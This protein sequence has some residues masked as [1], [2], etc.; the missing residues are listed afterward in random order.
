MNNAGGTDQI[1]GGVIEVEG[2]EGLFSLRV[3]DNQA[4]T[5]HP[6]I[7]ALT[8]S[9]VPGVVLAFFMPCEPAGATNTTHSP[10]GGFTEFWD[11]TVSGGALGPRGISTGKVDLTGASSFAP[12]TTNDN[13]AVSTKWAGI[14]LML[15]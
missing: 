15:S 1:T 6:I 12:G 14:A 4:S 8:G 13:A 10:D 7:T 9:G 5:N 2:V 11:V 3:L